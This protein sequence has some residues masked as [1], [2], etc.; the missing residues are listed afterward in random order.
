MRNAEEEEEDEG[1]GGGGGGGG[2]REK[3]KKKKKEKKKKKDCDPC[4]LCR[5]LE[6]TVPV[7][8]ALNTNNYQTNPVQ[9][10]FG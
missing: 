5:R 4:T 1:G 7:V 8:W 10:V 6:I 2:E 3:K 9:F